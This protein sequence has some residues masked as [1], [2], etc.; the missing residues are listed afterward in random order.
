[1]GLYNDSVDRIGKM[2]SLNRR[3]YGKKVD[4]ETN[5]LLDNIKVLESEIKKIDSD[6]KKEEDQVKRAIMELLREQKITQQKIE[7]QNVLIGNIWT[8]MHA[9]LPKIIKDEKLGFRDRK[10]F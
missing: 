10:G 5:K 1:M 8:Y 6:M 9:H 7:A 3:D 2:V 4:E